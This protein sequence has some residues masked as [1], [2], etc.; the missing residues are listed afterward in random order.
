MKSM[1]RQSTF[2]ANA[3]L[4][5]IIMLSIS[6]FM[7]NSARSETNGSTYLYLP[8]V[9]LNPKV[10]TVNFI[11]QLPTIP[12]SEYVIDLNFWD[13][14]A[15]G[16]DPVKTTDNIQ[17]AIDWASAQGYGRVVL[18][19]GD[20]LVGKYGNA[21]YQAGIELE[22]NMA[23][24]LD[25]NAT[26]RMA[27]NDKWNYCVIDITGETNVVVR[28]GTIIG[29]RE[30]HIYTPRQ[31][32]GSTVHDEG[33]LIC[34]KASQYVLV[35]NIHL[36]KANGDGILIVGSTVSGMAQD[37]TIRNSEFNNNR[38]QG[39]SIVGGIRVRIA[40]NEIHHTVGTSPQFGIDLEGGST[41]ENRDVHIIE[42]HFHNNKGGDI[43]NTDGRNVYIDDNVL[44]QGADSK[45]IDGPIVYWKNADQTIR[46]NSIQMTDFSVNV[47]AGII[48]YS[49]TSPKTNPATTYIYDNICDG[50]GFYMYESADLD[51][52]RNQLLDG[53]L[54]FKNFSNLT[55]I[56]N[57][58]TSTINSC[59]A[60]RF[61]NVQGQASGNTYN[62]APF[63]IPIETP[64]T[65]CWQ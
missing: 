20:Y 30:T 24:I 22:S 18:P 40:E 5:L 42:N 59:W 60:F 2:R 37:V 21:I 65:R 56:N 4:L 61:L 52:Q 47:K 27:T 8:L 19:A 45:Y 63:P 43:V 32:D 39:I 35:E 29:D 50:C 44:E 34:I 15:N 33:H 49:N 62:G 55:L 64:W 26:I 25:D 17:S 10:T 31:S 53:Y 9:A 54:A 58:V 57:V 38:R 46:Y 41:Y 7:P 36:Q 28:G 1:T 16:T 23:F 51:I 48:G 11:V 12:D 3:L 13:I 6:L 14:P